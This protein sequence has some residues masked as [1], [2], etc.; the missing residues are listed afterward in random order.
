[1]KT[2][3]LALCLPL[4]SCATDLYSPRT[5]AKLAHFGADAALIEYSG[6]GVTCR[7]VNHQPSRTIKA[8]GDAANKLAMT[9]AMALAA[10]VAVP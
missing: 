8:G 5:G 7:I 2:L 9:A 4:C 1:M 6:G 10:K 3:L